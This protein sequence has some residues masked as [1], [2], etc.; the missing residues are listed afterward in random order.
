MTKRRGTPAHH[1]SLANARNRREAAALPLLAHH[2]LVKIVTP[3]EMAT[4]EQRLDAMNAGRWAGMEFRQRELLHDACVRIRKVA[5]CHAEKL[6]RMTLF[7]SPYPDITLNELCTRVP[8]GRFPWWWYEPRALAPRCEVD[9]STGRMEFVYPGGRREYVGNSHSAD[10]RDA[11]NALC[12]EQYAM[13]DTLG[14]V[15]VDPLQHRA[16]CIRRTHLR[17]LRHM[18]ER[19]PLP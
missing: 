13:L 14:K 5:P 6:I 3:L 9:A 10:D 8:L 12:V 17:V 18:L 15:R 7:M 19:S 16:R 11:M 1:E 2:G 4:R